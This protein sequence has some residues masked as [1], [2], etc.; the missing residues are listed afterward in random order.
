M[1][2]WGGLSEGGW[3]DLTPGQVDGGVQDLVDEPHRVDLA[4]THRLLRKAREVAAPIHLLGEQSGRA[5]IGEDDVSVEA[6]EELVELVKVP[7]APRNVKL[8]QN[9]AVLMRPWHDTLQR[10][11][12]RS[13]DAFGAFR[14]RPFVRDALRITDRR[15]ARSE[16]HTSELQSPDHLV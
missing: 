7:R 11:R 6:K 1:G 5:E 15:S 12:S 9:G 3:I 14:G 13:R 4:G 8:H 10:C 16:E 2:A